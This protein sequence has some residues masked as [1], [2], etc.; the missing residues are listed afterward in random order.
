MSSPL[1]V[2]VIGGGMIVNDLILPTLYDLQRHE[3]IG[4]I[5]ICARGAASLRALADNPDL[6]E[7]LFRTNR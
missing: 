1:Q 5:A 6:A 2:S 7:W 4:D 3:R